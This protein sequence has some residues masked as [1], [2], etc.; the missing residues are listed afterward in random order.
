MLSEFEAAKRLG[1]SV[2]WLR[3]RRQSGGGPVFARFGTAVRY[4]ERK[5]QEFIE[6]CTVSSGGESTETMPWTR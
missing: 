4:P 3:K 6:T 2:S 1:V 5:L